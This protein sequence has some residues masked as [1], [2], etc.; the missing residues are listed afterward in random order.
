MAQARSCVVWVVAYSANSLTFSMASVVQWVAE[1]E[2][3][4]EDAGGRRGAGQW[5]SCAEAK[6]KGSRARKFKV[7][8]S[9]GGQVVSCGAANQRQR[10]ERIDALEQRCHCFRKR[11]SLGSIH[12][13]PVPEGSASFNAP[14]CSCT[15]YLP[16]RRRRPL[17]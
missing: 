10:L 14:G 5:Q 8:L 7:D 9:H 4:G 6:G 16:T 3:G 15:C 17:P 12:P 13:S 1:G 2:F 11:A